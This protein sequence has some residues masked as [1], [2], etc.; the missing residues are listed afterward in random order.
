MAYRPTYKNEVDSE[1]LRHIPLGHV[2][3]YGQPI[4]GEKWASV[5]DL[6][7]WS[8]LRIGTVRNSIRRLMA[9]EQITRYWD[10]NERYGRWIY[11]VKP[12]EK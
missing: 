7:R 6:L 3:E 12:T 10:G 2:T 4:D 5:T 9:R 8:G 11:A 1:V